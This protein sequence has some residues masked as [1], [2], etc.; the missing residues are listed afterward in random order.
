MTGLL[1]VRGLI[2]LAALLGL[3]CVTWR[4]PARLWTS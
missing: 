3:N 2:T 4:W 1:F